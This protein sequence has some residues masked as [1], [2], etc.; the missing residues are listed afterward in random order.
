MNL[1]TYLL[2]FTLLLGAIAVSANLW[3][4]ISFANTGNAGQ[5]IAG[6]GT[7]LSLILTITLLVLLYRRL[8]YPM[9]RIVQ[10]AE[11][12]ANGDFSVERLSETSN[13]EIGLLAGSANMILE[14]QQNILSEI[15]NATQQ[16]KAS[17]QELV[18]FGKQVGE[19]AN[20]VGSAIQQVA[21]GSEELT[22]QIAE[23]ASNIEYLLE[24]YNLVKQKSNQMLGAGE[25]VM[26]NISRGTESV[27]KS[28]DQMQA[29]N[30][31]V[32]GA[33]QTIKSLGA[34]SKE[35]GNIVTL[36][37][38]IADQTNLLALNAAIEAAR[39]GENGRGFA[40][41][42]EE[43][44]KLAEE[45]ANATHKIAALIKE[46]QSDISIAVI[47]MEQGMNEVGS[48][49]RAI[50]STG[51]VFEEIMVEAQNLLQHIKDVTTSTAKMSAS[52]EQVEQAIR[53]IADVSEEFTASSEEVAASTGEQVSRTEEI[54]AAAKY[55]AEMSNR[56]SSSMGRFN[57]STSLQ[58]TEDLAV[59]VDKIDSQHQELFSRIN[60]LLDACN[61][62]KGR[63]TVDE[64][65]KFLED[66]V[67]TH[68]TLEEEH[69]AKYAYSGYSDHK[70][71]HY[72][73]INSFSKLKEKI[74]REGVGS[75]ISIYTNQIVVDWLQ[76]H[77]TK[78]D[79]ALGKFLKQK[80]SA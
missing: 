15:G 70:E 12:V 39:A 57:L 72:Q 6:A 62:G 69:M 80:L 55:L 49:S 35:V 34:K 46:I 50:D 71:Q 22:A 38:N 19:S 27:A 16:V 11:K 56:L 24:Q 32:G 63:E 17:S 13:D 73:F 45:S 3:A 18:F 29:I 54:I 8:F 58:W 28:V 2:I 59:G 47:S 40:V 20:M 9:E 4:V 52:S 33:S 31:K 51:Q 21:E 66:Y 48:G 1:K 53:K 79:K 25:K 60:K 76:D 41:V 68:F 14:T 44:R 26:K 61:Q 75:H 23:S 42:A 78:T 64:I 7:F 30:T 74:E 67:V 77:I 65:I 5:L 43:V 10:F 36:I 37:N